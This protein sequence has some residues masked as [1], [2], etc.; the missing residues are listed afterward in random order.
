M[1]E[2]DDATGDPNVD[3]ETRDES[4][5]EEII[6]DA[7]VVEQ[8]VKKDAQEVMDAV[9]DGA[10]KHLKD[11]SD[12]LLYPTLHLIQS[13]SRNFK[14][15]KIAAQMSADAA[16]IIAQMA[17]DRAI[18]APMST[19]AAK[20]IAVDGKP[21]KAVDGK[22]DKAVDGKKL[23][24]V[25][26]GVKDPIA[27]TLLQDLMG[28]DLISVKEDY[29]KH[30]EYPQFESQEES[31]LKPKDCKSTWEEDEHGDDSNAKFQV[32]DDDPDYKGAWFTPCSV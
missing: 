13:L 29:W 31:Q 17:A 2:R 8:A 7:Q 32:W 19:D 18:D 4:V 1:R 15:Y 3:R 25:I 22:P 23:I 14:S 24:K 30:D 26:P 11:N 10:A 28:G 21:D 6:D 5:D 27:K 16:E 9:K 12:V 20:T